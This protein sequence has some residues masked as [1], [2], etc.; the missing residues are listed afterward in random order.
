MCQKDFIQN[1]SFLIKKTLLIFNDLKSVL[2]TT[3]LR[4]KEPNQWLETVSISTTCFFNISNN[5][6]NN[7]SFWHKK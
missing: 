6:S 3:I 7:I 1:T 5:S 4:T 2:K